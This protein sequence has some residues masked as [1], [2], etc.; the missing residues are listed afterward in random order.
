MAFNKEIYSGV[1][2][3]LKISIK[4]NEETNKGNEKRGEARNDSWTNR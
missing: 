3:K 4:G 1:F 2:K